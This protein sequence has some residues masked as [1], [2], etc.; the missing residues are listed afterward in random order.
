[1]AENFLNLKETDS[2]VQEARR[3]PNKTTPNQPTQ[4]IKGARKKVIYRGIPQSH[5]IISRAETSQ[6]KRKWHNIV[7]ILKEKILEE[8]MEQR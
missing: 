1:M 7:K 5:Q 6:A 8:I 4:G 2:Q 3:I